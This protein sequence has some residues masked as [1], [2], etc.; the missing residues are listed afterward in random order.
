MA[1]I[2]GT[3][4]SETVN[5]TDGDDIING[6]GGNDSLWGG[7]GSD[8]YLFTGT[9]GRDVIRD[10]EGANQIQIGADYAPS[11]FRLVNDNDHLYLEQIDGSQS[12][13]IYRYFSSNSV[14]TELESVV[15]L[16]DGTVWEVANNTA[17][18]NPGFIGTSASE[19]VSGTTWSDTIH[20]LGGNDR[21]RGSDGDDVY[22][23]SGAFGADDI[24]DTSGL[25][26]A[27]ITADYSERDF[28]PVVNFSNLVIRQ[29]GGS[30]SITLNGFVGGTA[31]LESIEFQR[32]GT[33]WD[34][35][36]G[37]VV[38]RPGFFDYDGYLAANPDVRAAGLDAYAHYVT[39]GWLEGRDASA[40]FDTTLYLLDNPDVAA[41]GLNPLQHYLANGQYE[42]RAAHAAVGPVGGGHFD[43]EYYLLANPD[44]GFAGIDA[45]THYA[46]SGWHEGRN[47]SAFFDTNYYLANNPDVAAAGL[48]PLAHYAASGWREGRDPSAAFSTAAYLAANPDVAAAGIDPLQHYLQSGLYEDRPLGV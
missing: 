25:D 7:G 27:V 40:R 29:I 23:F 6:V 38:A 33:V 22:I 11:D 2:D 18:R 24:T 34:L 48:N 36:S 46:T 8:I 16:R 35:S 31:S 10:G 13:Q 37:Q 41:A 28:T 12:I 42:G 26:R 17:F 47:P 39:S 20:G 14:A 44:V 19:T 32:T 45:A 30:Q 43:R 1:T 9:F 4:A 5:G 21:L 3:P 15:F